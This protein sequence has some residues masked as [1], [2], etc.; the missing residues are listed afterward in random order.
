[1]NL[2]KG[3]T[4]R[5][6]TASYAA[7]VAFNAKF[8]DYIKVNGDSEVELQV[9]PNKDYNAT[10]IGTPANSAVFVLNESYAFVSPRFQVETKELL[11]ITVEKIDHYPVTNYEMALS[12]DAIVYIS[13]RPLFSLSARA[14]GDDSDIEGGVDAG[15]FILA[16]VAG[17]GLV[18]YW[19]SVDYED[20]LNTLMNPT[21]IIVPIGATTIDAKPDSFYVVT[22]P[23]VGSRTFKLPDAESFKGSYVTAM[24]AADSTVSLTVIPSGTDTLNGG[25]GTDLDSPYDRIVV[26]STGVEWVIVH[27]IVT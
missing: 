4:K 20:V 21:V 5:Y 22:T 1:M 15:T 16:S 11:E 24:M 27:L 3:T 7:K 2:V 26:F 12:S 17:M 13:N 14:T 9:N 8:L 23:A 18:L 25:A 6:E 19:T 10:N